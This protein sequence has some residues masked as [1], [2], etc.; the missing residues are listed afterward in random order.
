MLAYSQAILLLST[1]G[2]LNVKKAEVEGPA[3]D[4]PAMGE[5]AA[6]PEMQDSFGGKMSAL[7][8]DLLG[9]TMSALEKNLLKMETPVSATS[10][11]ETTH[12]KGQVATKKRSGRSSVRHRSASHSDSSTY[13]GC[14]SYYATTME[15]SLKGQWY[16]DGDESNPHESDH[17]PLAIRDHS[18]ESDYMGIVPLSDG[19]ISTEEHTLYFV[20]MC[21]GGWAHFISPEDADTTAFNIMIKHFIRIR[22]FNGPLHEDRLVVC[23]ATADSDDSSEL[24]DNCFSVDRCSV[25]DEHYLQNQLGHHYCPTDHHEDDAGVKWSNY[26]TEQYSL[27]EGARTGS[28]SW[29]Q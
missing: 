25:H 3:G 23:H 17:A 2:A 22:D 26:Q 9:G 27:A 1:V 24:P 6:P 11:L 29:P 4:E 18:T 14:D 16:V 7:E 13:G 10:L 21:S 12:G 8:K 5:M 28:T 19:T 15:A 20:G